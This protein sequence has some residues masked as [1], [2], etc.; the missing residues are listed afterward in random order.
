MLRRIFDAG[1]E[2]ALTKVRVVASR[3]YLFRFFR[4]FVAGVSATQ[5]IA[6]LYEHYR[7]QFVCSGGFVGSSAG[8][9]STISNG[10]SMDAVVFVA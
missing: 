5:G 8:A 1:L 10:L 2:A 3:T 6:T 7:G 9:E 4:F